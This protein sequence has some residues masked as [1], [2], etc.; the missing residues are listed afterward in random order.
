[1]KAPPVGTALGP[2]SSHRPAAF[3]DPPLAL[4]VFSFGRQGRVAPPTNELRTRL[5]R[6]P[7]SAMFEAQTRT[8]S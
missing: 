1:M 5:A 6:V 2:T 3:V 8:S 7:W 4:F